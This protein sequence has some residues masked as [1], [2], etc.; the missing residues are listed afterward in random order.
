MW[1]AET[2]GCVI[3]ALMAIG[4]KHGNDE[5]NQPDIKQNMLAKKVEFETRFKEKNKSLI[6]REILG[7]DLSKEEEMKIIMDKGLLFSVCPRVVVSACE[8]LD[9]VL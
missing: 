3:G 1:H 7:Y 4:L 5:A 9:E 8:I 6:C 2:C